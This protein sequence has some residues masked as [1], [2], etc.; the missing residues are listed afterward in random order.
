M[1]K[2]KQN[3]T[4]N[5]KEVRLQLGILQEEVAEFF[6]IRQSHISYIERTLDKNASVRILWYLRSRGVDL[7][8]IFDESEYSCIKSFGENISVLFLWYLRSRKV[9]LNKVLDESNI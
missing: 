1:S 2:N 5:I 7:N 8:K 3:I 4:G 6:N 9:D